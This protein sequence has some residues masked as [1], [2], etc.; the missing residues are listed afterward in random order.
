MPK[1]NLF[2]NQIV[3]IMRVSNRILKSFLLQWQKS[4]QKGKIC[5]ERQ[6]KIGVLIV[7]LMIFFGALFFFLDEDSVKTFNQSYHVVFITTITSIAGFI[8]TILVSI[9]KEKSLSNLIQT[10]Q[11]RTRLQLEN[12]LR[13]VEHDWVEGVL[14]KHTVLL[15]LGKEIQPDQVQCHLDRII[16]IDKQRTL[17]SAET[18]I[19]Q[20]FEN[21][22][23][24]QLL[25]LGNP[26]S[27]KTTT[28][29]QLAKELI[30]EARLNKDLPIPVVFDLS[31]WSKHQKPIEE[32]LIDELN[33][34][35]KI[36][37][38]MG[39][40]WFKQHHILPLL[41][42]LDEVKAEA[43]LK[44][45]NAIN[46][47][48][49]NV[50]ITGLA[51]CCRAEE[52]GDLSTQLCLTAAIHL[53][54]LNNAQIDHYLQTAGDS[55]A[56]LDQLLKQD[57]ELRDLATSPL[58]LSI[59]GAAYQNVAREELEETQHFNDKKSQLFDR[60]IAKM[61]SRRKTEEKIYSDQKV[62]KILSWFAFQMQQH[63]QSTFLVENLQPTWLSST[64]VYRLL[65]G[66]FLGVFWGSVGYFQ[67][68]SLSYVLTF[69]VIAGIFGFLSGYLNIETTEQVGWSWIAFRQRW[70]QRVLDDL[71][72]AV[73]L[74]MLLFII[75][76]SVKGASSLQGAWFGALIGMVGGIFLG[77]LEAGLE[78]TIPE[79]KN[80][81]NQGILSS[82]QNMLRFGIPFGLTFGFVAW[83]VLIIA[84]SFAKVTL[85]TD[86]FSGILFGGILF[87]FL[88]FGAIAVVQH[89]VLRLMLYLEGFTPLNIV[90]FLNYASRLILL[91]KVGGSFQFIHRLLLEHF[92]A[93]Y[94]RN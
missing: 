88:Q 93:K 56:T 59:M 28:L 80:R 11:Q 13:Q 40:T 23:V 83:V 84:A 67:E 75:L 64:L 79:H 54:P 25:I 68:V 31:S 72:I 27:G 50:N 5:M 22:A 36:P 42:G 69:G 26:G 73:P 52:Y 41:D 61:L 15:E 35:Y 70:F 92:A 74:T 43:R 71:K 63:T 89:Y 1:N 39:T 85:L 62:I 90:R 38:E 3:T 29:L 37:K 14:K 6:T 8:I 44:C 46:V 16:E 4:K 19:L 77:L 82:V 18:T 66:L 91:R 34:Q 76:D 24:K 17:L 65:L 81:V 32:W 78:Q 53:Q 20:V 49:R 57:Q 33:E 45:L 21:Q 7:L 86:L 48:I 94:P 30:E 87:G 2:I 10:E 47:F 9:F 55:L 60:Y 12:L 51:V 58:M